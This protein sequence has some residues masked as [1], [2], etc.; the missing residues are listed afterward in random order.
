MLTS[1]TISIHQPTYTLQNSTN[2]KKLDVVRHNSGK[3]SC[4]N[5]E[6]N[7]NGEQT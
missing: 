4:I 2:R 6:Y 5:L 7:G 3:H 1:A